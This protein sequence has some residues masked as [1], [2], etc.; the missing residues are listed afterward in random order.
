LK[1]LNLLAVRSP[2]S[3]GQGRSTLPT[4]SSEDTGFWRSRQIQPDL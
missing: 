1:Q 3:Y 4:I 2:A